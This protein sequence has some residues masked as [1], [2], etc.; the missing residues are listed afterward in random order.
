GATDERNQRGATVYRR[1]AEPD[2]DGDPR[3]GAAA[4]AAIGSA[5]G[6]GGLPAADVVRQ[7]GR[8]AADRSVRILAPL[9]AFGQGARGTGDRDQSA[10]PWS[11]AAHRQEAAAVGST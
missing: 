7:E 1:L 9:K 4:E 5:I 11:R 3:Q 2:H 10:Q 6:R 8:V